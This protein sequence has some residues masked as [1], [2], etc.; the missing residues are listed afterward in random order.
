MFLTF[1][2]IAHDGSTRIRAHTQTH[3]CLAMLVRGFHFIKYKLQVVCSVYLLCTQCTTRLHWC[4]Y[5]AKI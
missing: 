1:R 5:E 2:W 4:R 3:V